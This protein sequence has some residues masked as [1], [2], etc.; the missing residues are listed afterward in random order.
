METQ[1]TDDDETSTAGNKRSDVNTFFWLHF[2]LRPFLFS[3]YV[4]I[5]LD[6]AEGGGHFGRPLLAREFVGPDPSP[7]VRSLRRR[8][9]GGPPLGCFVL[10]FLQ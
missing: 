4:W 3:L 1:Q 10:A 7:V 5:H 8:A 6:A 9:L 2:L